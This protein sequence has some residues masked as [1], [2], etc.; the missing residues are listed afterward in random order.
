MIKEFEKIPKEVYAEAEKYGVFRDAVRIALRCDKN[1]DG[2]FCDSWIL[3]TDDEILIIGGINLVV[4]KKNV[5]KSDPKKLTVRF[6]KISADTIPLKELCGFKTERLASGCILTAYDKACGNY[7]LITYASRQ[8]EEDLSELC[9]LL[10]PP[11]QQSASFPDADE[12]ISGEAFSGAPGGPPGGPG[13]GPGGP[14]GTHGQTPKGAPGGKRSREEECCP[15]CGRKY[16]NPDTKICPYC[17]KKLSVIKTLFSFV[18]KYKFSV[19]LIFIS[20]G[21]MSALSVISPYVSSEFFYDKVLTEGGEFYGQVLLVI[22]LIV[23]LKVISLLVEMVS[24]IIQARVVP[25]FVYDLKKTIF[26]AV[27]KM[28]LSFFTNRR[29]GSLMNQVNGDANTIYWF[30]IEGLPYLI[31]NI[32]QTAAVVCVVFFIDWRLALIALAFCPLAILFSKYLF[33]SMNKLHARRYSASRSMSGVLSDVLAGVRVVKAFSREKDEIERFDKRSDAEAKASQNVNV[34]S[35]IAFPSLSFLF[36]ISSALVTAI[37]GYFVITGQMT[38]GKLLAFTAY[39]AMLYSPLNFFVNITQSITNCFNATFRLMEVMDAEPDVVE[40]ENPVSPE[41]ITGR[42]TF[43]RVS[44]GYD[45]TRR[46]INDVSFDIEAGGTIG[47]VGHTGAGKSTIV[48][49]LIRLYDPDEGTIM[50]DGINTRDLS[51]KAIRD[52]IAIVSQE[53]YLFHGTI[54]DN[55]KY[56][57]PDATNEEVITAAKISGAHD[58]IMKLPDGY[59]TEIGWGHKDLSGG[60]RQRVSIAR[61]I[62]RDPKILILDEATSAMDTKTERSIQT[63]LEKLCR[64]RTTIMI[65]H[66]LSTLRGCDK[67]LVIEKGRVAEAGTHKELIEKRGIYFKLYS[68]QYEALKNAGVEE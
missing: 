2:V 48:N 32:L 50:L 1:P 16:P 3:I 39:T 21:L 22:G 66:R 45:K 58:F 49:L 18:K 5:K 24:N 60:E 26:L 61:A 25:K 17:T 59:E 40:A 30:F 46:V 8:C 65:A 13:G 41:N 56:A 38:Y 47:I 34:F 52:N 42:V 28:S 14:G 29:T 53:T 63:A 68:L 37:G 67:L 64:G 27:E 35:G 62:L 57:K 44:F 12:R 54:L 23:S 9:N 7:K 11:E 55:I 20:M 15:K 4:P 51:F 33:N 19:I 36:V 31:I 6:G 43:D 10:N